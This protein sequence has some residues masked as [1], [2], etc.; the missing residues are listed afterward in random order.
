MV[1]LFVALRLGV[2]LS[3]TLTLIVLVLSAWL[4]SGRQVNSALVALSG[5]NAA[6]VGAVSKAK[7]RVC[8]GTVGIGHGIS[9]SQRDARVHG[10][11]SDRCENWRRVIVQLAR[12]R[13]GAQRRQRVAEGAVADS[14]R[15]FAASE[16]DAV[17]IHGV[18]ATAAEKFVR[19]M[20]WVKVKL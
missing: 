1:K 10:P 7:V 9:D 18:S 17:V 11:V 8:A 13:H 20:V 16:S 19:V 5:A 3:V 12:K 4:T 15:R 2:P 6:L 14:D